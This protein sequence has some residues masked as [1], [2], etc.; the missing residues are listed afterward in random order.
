MRVVEVKLKHQP[1]ADSVGVCAIAQVMPT[2]PRVDACPIDVYVASNMPYEYP[3][4][5]VK[6]AHVS[7]GIVDSCETLIMDSGIGDDSVSNTDVLDLANKYDADMVVAKDYLHDQDRTTVSV[8]DFLREWQY[9]DCRATPLIPLQPPHH[10]HYRE[11][12]G[13]YHYLLGGMAF[14]WDT[15]R[16]IDAVRS[17]RERIGYGPYVHLLG[18]GANQKLM[19]FL[20]RN[21]DMVQSIDCSTPE[22]CAINSNIYDVT[23]KQRDY[24]IRTGEGSTATRTDLSQHLA[25]TLCDAITMRYES[26]KQ[27]TMAQYV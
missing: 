1:K 4:K 12:E 3:Y 21:P 8:K 18:V 2:Y 7:Q 5:L 27:Q 9:H 14:G 24:Q 10:E 22:Q 19:D 13:Q 17:F 11:L 6:P 15:R 20:A 26:Q 23:L 16:I 25:K